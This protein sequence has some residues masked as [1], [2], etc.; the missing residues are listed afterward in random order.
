MTVTLTTI[1]ICVLRSWNASS[2]QSVFDGKMRMS[3][4]LSL[5]SREGNAGVV[6]ACAYVRESTR[7]REHSPH[8]AHPSY[9]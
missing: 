6:A 8:G 2:A 1:S 9:V 7:S 4:G 3:A 5:A